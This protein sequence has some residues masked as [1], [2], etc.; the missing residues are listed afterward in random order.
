VYSLK[1]NSITIE[2]TTFQE[3]VFPDIEQDVCL[4]FLSNEKTAKPFV[5]YTT[6]KKV[7]KNRISYLKV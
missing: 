2:I 7:L 6:V 1:K 3:Q 5:K 4:V